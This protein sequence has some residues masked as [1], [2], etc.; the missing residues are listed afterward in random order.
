MRQ[1]FDRIYNKQYIN[2]MK[3]RVSDNGGNENDDEVI[4]TLPTPSELSRLDSMSQADLIGLVQRMACQCGLVALMSEDEREQ[5]LF[6]VLATKGIKAMDVPAI[7]EYFDRKKGK[8][9]QGI[10]QRLLGH[11]T[12]SWED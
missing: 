10:D 12:I 4:E 7:K 5:A 9:I 6:D 3:Q 1:E 2:Y 11:M 8:P